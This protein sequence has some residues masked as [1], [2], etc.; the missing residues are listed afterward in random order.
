MR[1]KDSSEVKA[2]M[3]EHA[4]Q[5]L[6]R[7]FFVVVPSLLAIHFLLSFSACSEED[8]AKR[9]LD[10]VLRE[11]I[12]Q[13]NKYHQREIKVKVY[14]S[15]GRYYR[16]YHEREEPTVNMRRTNSV[17]TPYIA[18]VSFK[19]NIYLTRKSATREDCRKDSHFLLSDSSKREIVYA[20]A[21]GSW[22]KKEVY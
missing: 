13:F 6:R 15:G 16:V 11:E 4:L 14:E 12:N 17:D 21:G 7:R 3:L 9:A 1:R 22:R 18:T 10:Q 8:R 2:G 19:E 20:F 5:K